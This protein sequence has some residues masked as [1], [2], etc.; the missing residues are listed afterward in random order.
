[1]RTPSLCL[2]A[3]GDR[4]V[5]DIIDQAS[6]PA[7]QTQ[8]LTVDR[9]CGLMSGAPRSNN[10]SLVAESIVAVGLVSGGERE[11]YGRIHQE[12]RRSPALR[13]D[14]TLVTMAPTTRC[15]RG[16]RSESGYFLVTSFFVFS[17][18]S[19]GLWSS[20]FDLRVGFVRLRD[21]QRVRRW[22]SRAEPGPLDG[23]GLSGSCLGC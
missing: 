21:G 13:D 17:A 19:R 1:M 18:S 20:A 11:K 7:V 16:A 22:V 4:W 14:F 8:V 10:L 2:D 5:P 6:V 12:G 15:Y 9:A 3:S 23:R